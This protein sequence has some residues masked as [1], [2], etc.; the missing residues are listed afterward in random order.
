MRNAYVAAATHKGET[1]IEITIKPE[2]LTKGGGGWE[3]LGVVLRLWNHTAAQNGLFCGL[4]IPR[5][6]P[7]RFFAVVYPPPPFS[8]PHLRLVSSSFLSMARAF[9]FFF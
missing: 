5:T 1:S 9:L 3:K 4:F 8:N 2:V 6:D 7:T